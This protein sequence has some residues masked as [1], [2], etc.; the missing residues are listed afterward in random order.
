[1]ESRET[2]LLRYL[3]NYLVGTISLTELKDF[4]VAATWQLPA[5]E[6]LEARELAYDVEL[7]LAEES[8]G[9]LTDDELRED[10]RTIR[11]RYTVKIHA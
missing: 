9:Y 1:M 2:A 4:I 7:A 11:D 10:L 8:S 6:S 3:T 5:T